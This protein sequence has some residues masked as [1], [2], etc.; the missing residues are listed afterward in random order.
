[1]Y[2]IGDNNVIYKN[3]VPIAGCNYTRTNQKTAQTRIPDTIMKLIENYSVHQWTQ[4]I[5]TI[6]RPHIH[7]TSV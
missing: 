1:M 3:R 2:D 6:Q 5:H 4:N 7:T